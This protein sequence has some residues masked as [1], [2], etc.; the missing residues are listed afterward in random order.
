MC[1]CHLKCISRGAA[2]T[3]SQ[4]PQNEKLVE[5]KVEKFSNC[6]PAGNRAF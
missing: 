4:R 2:K 1:A 5:T 6:F 3:N